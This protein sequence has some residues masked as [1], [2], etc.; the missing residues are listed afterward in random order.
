M[1]VII[2]RRCVLV[3]VLCIVAGAMPSERAFVRKRNV[4]LAWLAA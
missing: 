4:A 2:K 1:R 3:A